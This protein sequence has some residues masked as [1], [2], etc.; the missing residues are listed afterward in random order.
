MPNFSHHPLY[1]FDSVDLGLP[2]WAQEKN[3]FHIMGEPFALLPEESII[4]K[5]VEML[6]KRGAHRYVDFLVELWDRNELIPRL[7]LHVRGGF[8]SPEDIE[9]SGHSVR[10]LF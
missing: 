4:V 2:S 9:V 5:T 7:S 10:V 3:A 8:I 1:P 6:K